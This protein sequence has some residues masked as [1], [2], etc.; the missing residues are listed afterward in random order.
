[1][2][3]DDGATNVDQEVVADATA[4]SPQQNVTEGAQASTS[5]EPEQINEGA[6]A[7]EPEPATEETEDFDPA[8]QYANYG[9]A[10]YQFQPAED[11]TVDPNQVA[12]QIEQRLLNQM[13]FE[14]QEAR[15]WERLET[16]YPEIKT[17]KGL[18]DLIFNQRVAE[19]VQGK[20]GN[21]NKIADGI[22]ERVKGARNEGKAQAG[23]STKVQKAASLETSTANTGSQKSDDRMDRIASGDKAAASDL[24]AEWL[25]AG[26][27]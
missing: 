9:Q 21:L 8:S 7:P 23:V 26:K 24:L 19:V 11:G 4:E 22:M 25:D 14:R 15:S 1:M 13:R 10:A 17:D 5:Q 20:Q 27:L 6:E 16:K 12:S 3:D 18:R 2:A